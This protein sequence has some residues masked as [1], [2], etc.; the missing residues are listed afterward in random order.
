MKKEKILLIVGLSLFL[1]VNLFAFDLG[2]F[3]TDKLSG[4][5]N[6]PG[7]QQLKPS[8]PAIKSGSAQSSETKGVQPDVMEPVSGSLGEDSNSAGNYIGAW[9]RQGVYV[10]GKLQNQTPATL[11]YK[12]DTFSASGTC[13]TSGTIDVSGNTIKTIMTQTDCPGGVK[14]PLTIVYKYQLTDNGK[15][16]ILTTGPVK[17]IYLRKE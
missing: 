12:K 15:K 2:S 17:E 4:N 1:T 14:A 13:S 10:S 7:A 6:T 3:L 5:A 8:Q 16:M 9:L 11:I